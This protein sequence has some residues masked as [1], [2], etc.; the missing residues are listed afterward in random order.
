MV[1]ACQP[2][3][4]TSDQATVIAFPTVT[5]GRA[6]RG[7]LATP[8]GL[9]LNGSNLSNPA[10]AI[11]AANQPTA[12]PNYSACPQIIDT[13]PGA[14]PT[15]TRDAIDALLTFL[16]AGG[17][18]DRLQAILTDWQLLGENGLVR[19]DI[20]LTGEGVPEVIVDYVTPDDIGTLLII[21]CANGQ[22][23]QLFQAN[24]L[25]GRAPEIVTAGDMNFD[26][27]ADL[28]FSIQHCANADICEYETQLLTW[29]TLV[30]RFVNLLSPPIVSSVPPEIRDIDNDQVLEIVARLRDRGNAET[31]PLRT[32]VNIYDWNGAVYV[33][34]IAQPDPPRFTIQ[35]VHEADRA[36]AQREMETAITLY[37]LA[38]E[39]ESLEP[40][41]N[42]DPYIFDG[43]IL[44]RLLL[45]Y[46]YLEDANLL[47]QYQRLVDAYPDPGA[48]P[49]YVDLGDT[50]WNGL[51]VTNNLH[52]ACLEVLDLIDQRADALDL[53]NR[54]GSRSPSYTSAE[55]CPF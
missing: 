42:D 20:D 6:I 17:A 15:T 24:N 41:Y 25:E 9:L 7:V 37:T 19:A 3:P 47:G 28:L 2:T 31:G 30:G 32:G 14:A 8:E 13:Q 52:S 16:N 51:Q 12:T 10:T 54:Y 40:W 33:L 36:F 23:V 55:L 46:A 18:P 4:P 45:T 5:V 35:I 44:Y 49:V 1:A 39:D 38:L 11:A 43:Y 34:S 50:F 27:R 29:V 22:Y 21:S 48:R 53:I 26:N